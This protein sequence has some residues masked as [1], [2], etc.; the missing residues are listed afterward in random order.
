MKVN[1]S[2]NI[3]IREVSGK[4]G[5]SDGKVCIEDLGQSKWDLDLSMSHG[6]VAAVGIIK[7]GCID[8]WSSICG[9]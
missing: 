8:W 5:L 4:L 9:W 1:M 7:L 3:K 6:K 2:F